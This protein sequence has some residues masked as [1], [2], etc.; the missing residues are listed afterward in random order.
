[1]PNTLDLDKFVDSENL[2]KAVSIPQ[3][4]NTIINAA[5]AY[6]S[7]TIAYSEGIKRIVYSG[8]SKKFSTLAKTLLNP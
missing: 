6:I 7:D 5:Y 4:P 1:V 2:K 3:E 8:T